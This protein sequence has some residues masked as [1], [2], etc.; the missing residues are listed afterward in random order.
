MHFSLRLH[1]FWNDLYVEIVIDKKKQFSYK[2]GKF[3]YIL[4]FWCL[5]L[6][7]HLAIF[8]A[9]CSSFNKTDD[10]QCTF[11][12]NVDFF[13]YCDERDVELFN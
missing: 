7:E 5:T 3:L 1:L 8:S 11:G 13:N 4:I 9:S 2:K 10:I 6:G 12:E